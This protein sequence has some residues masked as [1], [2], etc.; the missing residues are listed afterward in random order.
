LEAAP[1]ATAADDALELAVAPP[2]AVDCEGCDDGV[3][4]V[5]GNVDE[6]GDVWVGVGASDG[7]VG[8]SLGWVVLFADVEPAGLPG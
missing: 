2:A 8:A 6:L 1:S 7:W 4:E 5:L 3:T